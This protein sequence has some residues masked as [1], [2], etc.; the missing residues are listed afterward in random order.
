MLYK[1]LWMQR[2]WSNK[3]SAHAVFHLSL[4]SP[5]F[6]N[7]FILL[8]IIGI[9]LAILVLLPF[10]SPL[11]TTD[12]AR[13]QREHSLRQ[14]GRLLPPPWPAPKLL[15]QQ[16][17]LPRRGTL[18]LHAPQRHMLVPACLLWRHA[19]LLSL[20]PLYVLRLTLFMCLHWAGWSLLVYVNIC[21]WCI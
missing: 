20:V 21:W 13:G 3:L 18:L 6:C 14:G 12:R 4:L 1:K 2:G 19:P 15:H 10:L 17:A 11:P 5:F 9:I 16:L 8:L 7:T